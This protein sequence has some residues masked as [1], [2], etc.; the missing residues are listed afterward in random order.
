[1]PDDRISS[2]PVVLQRE[3]ELTNAASSER[4][5]VAGV[6]RSL[7]G[8]SSFVGM[9]WEGPDTVRVEIDKIGALEARLVPERGS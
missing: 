6:P 1:M 4:S 3:S 2:D 7:D 9:R 8:V 5:G